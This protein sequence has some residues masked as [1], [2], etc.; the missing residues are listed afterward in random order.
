VQEVPKAPG[1]PG[2]TLA[3][4]RGPTVDI[5]IVNWNSGRWLR[6]CLRALADARP[7]ACRV[8]R[9]VVVDNASSDGSCDGIGDADAFELPLP[10]TIVRNDVNRGFA[11]ACNQGAALP[12]A[13]ASGSASAS[14]S[15][16]ASASPLASASASAPASAP[17]ADYLL[18]LNPDTVPTAEA[19]DG[20]IGL[21][22]ARASEA[23]KIAGV[24]LDNGGGPQTLWLGAFPTARTFMLQAVG[25]QQRWQ[26]TVALAPSASLLPNGG[27]DPF[28]A[29]EVA[30]VGG[31]FFVIERSLFEELDG[32][33]ERFFMY[34]DELDLCLRAR[35]R[36]ARAMVASRIRIHHQVGASTDRVPGKRLFYLLRSRL[37]YA[38]AHFTTPQTAALAVLMCS[39]E[40]ILRLGRAAAGRGPDRVRDV[41]EGYARFAASLVGFAPEGHR[42]RVDH[43]RK[44]TARPAG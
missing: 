23:V 1:P 28:G 42:S 39:T 24:W 40:P 12:S 18:F 16:L 3:P 21:L 35:Q 2:L 38:R 33:D 30:V 19:L 26:E 6:E 27:D 10:L 43:S 4:P 44:K 7:A 34:F 15:E 14:A 20:A 25:R 13:S 9:V 5:V 8:S 41:L 22:K 32:F 37:R 11:A 31:A 17:R 36:G 29:I